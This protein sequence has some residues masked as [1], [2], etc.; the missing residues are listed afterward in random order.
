MFFSETVAVRCHSEKLFYCFH[1]PL[2]NT[3]YISC[4]YKDFTPISGLFELS[5]F[6]PLVG[7]LFE[8][9]MRSK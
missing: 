6:F 7:R 2:D 9:L 8:R 1:K 3:Q 5:A 4:F